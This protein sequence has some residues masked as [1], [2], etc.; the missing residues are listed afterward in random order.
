M[1]LHYLFNFR[2]IWHTREPFEGEFKIDGTEMKSNKTS[3]DS[4]IA[5]SEAVHLKKSINDINVQKISSSSNDTKE[6][7][8]EFGANYVFLYLEHADGIETEFK[9]HTITPKNEL[10][11]LLIIPQYFVMTCGEVMFSITGL[12]FAFSQVSYYLLCRS[13]LFCFGQLTRHCARLRIS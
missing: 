9:Q 1:Y 2:V 6:V 10:H 4:R 12:E 11:M 8:F 3:F 5:D 7:T 13:L